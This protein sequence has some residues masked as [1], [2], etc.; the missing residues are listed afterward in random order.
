MSKRS[1]F[2]PGDRVRST[3]YGEGFLHQVDPNDREFH[4][5][6]HFAD[7]TMIWMGKKFAESNLKLVHRPTD[8]VVNTMPNGVLRCNPIFATVS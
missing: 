2:L 7:G 6:F 8:P 1:P 3:K 5:D 4:Y